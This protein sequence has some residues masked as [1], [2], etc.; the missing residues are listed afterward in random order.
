MAD[1]PFPTSSRS[2]PF[3]SPPIFSWLA[4]HRDLARGWAKEIKTEIGQ[5]DSLIAVLMKELWRAGVEVVS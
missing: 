4:A 3:P 5:F 1:E 2:G